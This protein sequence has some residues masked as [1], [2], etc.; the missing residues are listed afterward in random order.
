M[1]R[2]VN[3]ASDTGTTI[4]RF[5]SKLG[6]GIRTLQKLVRHHNEIAAWCGAPQVPHILLGGE[7]TGDKAKAA[8]E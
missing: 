1:K 2:F 8:N 6:S 3:E 7:P 5:V 4:Y